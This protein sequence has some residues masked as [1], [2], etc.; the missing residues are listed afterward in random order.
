MKR[1]LIALLVGCALFTAAFASAASLTVDGG[2]IQAGV[3]SSLTCDTGGVLVKWKTFV[4]GA[5]FK[6][7]GVEIQDISG[8]CVGGKVLVALQS[9]PGSQVG[10]ARGNIVSDG[11]GGG[12]AY[13]NEFYTSVGGVWGW[14]DGVT[15]VGPKAEDVN[16]ISVVLK[17]GWVGYDA[18]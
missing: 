5:D 17:N 3:D 15:G 7:A 13:C 18:P 2:Y 8:A 6:V 11:A 10:F 14:Y 12:I 9:A 4:S 1:F 16:L